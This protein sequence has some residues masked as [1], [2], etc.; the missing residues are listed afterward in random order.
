MEHLSERYVSSYKQF[1]NA[2]MH[3][4]V[5]A[6]YHSHASQHNTSNNEPSQKSLRDMVAVLW[7]WQQSWHQFLVLK[8]TESDFH[9]HLWEQKT[10]FVCPKEEDKLKS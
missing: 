7:Q 3:N 6:P 10:L 1:S 8:K 5:Q 2:T 9:D 4:N